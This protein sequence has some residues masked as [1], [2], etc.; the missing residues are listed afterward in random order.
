[1][2]ASAAPPVT[3]KPPAAPDAPILHEILKIDFTNLFLSE[4]NEAFFKMPEG[5]RQV[6]PTLMPEI[7]GINT[8]IKQRHLNQTSFRL[9]IDRQF[10][11][12]EMLR[13]LN[14]VKWW[15]IRPM[16]KVIPPIDKLGIPPMVVERLLSLAP[17]HGLILTCGGTGHGKTTTAAS[18][19]QAWLSR[20]GDVAV[21]IEDPPEMPLNGPYKNG[22]GFC[23]QEHY[24][25]DRF[26][27]AVVAALRKNPRFIYIGEIRT[28]EAAVAAV[29]AALS[30]HLV[31]ST[32][33]GGSVI[34]SLL[35]FQELLASETGSD[36]SAAL[37]LADAFVCFL[38]QR[39]QRNPRKLHCEWLFANPDQQDAV[40]AKLREKKIA[41]LTSDIDQQ[42][43]QMASRIAGT[44]A[45]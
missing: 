21:T 17:Q 37:Q 27:D 13:P 39:L 23:F 15:S 45:A 5:I 7:E 38:H 14:G 41:H 28:K 9:R 44:D 40:R 6:T 3:A 33:H 20:Y 42:R 32:L 8:I 25:E 11:R 31:L 12:A 19:L 34:N 43:R 16:P 18:L 36:E 24:P 30:G 26:P 22:G 10:Y 4:R 2:T 1:M 35:R 29:R